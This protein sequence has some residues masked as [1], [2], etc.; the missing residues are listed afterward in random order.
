[1]YDVYV[2]RGV[3]APYCVTVTNVYGEQV[4]HACGGGLF[5][6]DIA[7]AGRFEFGEH[8][9]RGVPD[10]RFSYGLGQHVTLGFAAAEPEGPLAIDEV[11]AREQR[12]TDIQFWA[13]REDGP[14]DPDSYRLIAHDRNTEYFVSRGHAAQFLCVSTLTRRDDSTAWGGTMCGETDIVIRGFGE[15]HTSHFSAAGFEGETPSG[16]R[17]V[18]PFLR[19]KETSGAP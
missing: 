8:H 15:A 17:Q 9:A 16:W 1:M 13:D 12:P 11:F 6:G 18:S 3:T 19:V 7:G 14:G 4:G 5:G 10:A 2:S